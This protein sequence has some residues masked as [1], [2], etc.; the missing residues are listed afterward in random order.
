MVRIRAALAAIL[1]LFLLGAPA[2]AHAVEYLVTPYLSFPI[3]DVLEAS[4]L[5]SWGAPDVAS[6][7]LNGDGRA[8]LAVVSRDGTSIESG[9]QLSI[10]FSNSNP[11]LPLFD[12]PILYQTGF[13]PQAVAIAEL[14]SDGWLDVVTV[15]AGDNAISVF[16]NQGGGKL[17]PRTTYS[18]LGNPGSLAI[19]DLNADGRR[20][21]V[22]C[23]GAGVSVFLASGFPGVFGPPTAYG[24]TGVARGVA[25]GLVD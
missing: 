24:T 9:N 7:D 2:A 10:L 5:S 16:F 1:S 22:V 21:I 4:P 15:D 20:D 18:T 8:D 11:S 14:N 25:V 13:G 3:G 12:P 23:V 17:G 19:A 6:G